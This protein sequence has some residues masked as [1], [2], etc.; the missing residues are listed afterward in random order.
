MR[1]SQVI[2]VK[3]PEVLMAAHMKGHESNLPVETQIRSLMMSGPLN[4]ATDVPAAGHPLCCFV[5]RSSCSR[6]L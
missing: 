6:W 4:G 5:P 1:L 2:L 3:T